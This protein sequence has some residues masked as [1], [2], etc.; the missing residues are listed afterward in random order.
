MYFFSG[1]RF[2]LFLLLLLLLHCKRITN[3]TSG[4]SLSSFQDDHCPDTGRASSKCRTGIVQT[5]DVH[6]PDEGQARTC[7]RMSSKCRTS[8]H[9][10][11]NKSLEA[12]SWW[13]VWL[14][15]KQD[16]GPVHFPK[17]IKKKRPMHTVVACVE[18]CGHLSSVFICCNEMTL[19][20]EW[21]HNNVHCMA[22]HCHDWRSQTELKS[23]ETVPFLVFYR[24]PIQGIV[25]DE[26]KADTQQGQTF[27]RSVNPE[28]EAPSRRHTPM[29]ATG[30]RVFSN[31]II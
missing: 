11:K 20:R 23:L 30:K 15:L 16:I 4:W 1:L 12:L 19:H 8:K 9:L 14:D 25:N 6:R 28:R 26:R 31:E 7:R 2:L 13:M 22:H 27:Y 29:I 18:G 17:C 24:L 10:H 21:K 3:Q 5:Q